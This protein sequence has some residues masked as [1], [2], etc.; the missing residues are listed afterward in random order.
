MIYRKQ[1][2]R[3][4]FPGGFFHLQDE[5]SKTRVSGFGNGEYIR[6]KDE[7]GNIWQ[8]SAEHGLGTS[9]VYRFKD[10]RGRTLTGVSEDLVVTLRD[11][12]GNTWKGIIA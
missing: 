5:K 10:G 12:S 4:Q 6:L 3:K 9:V 7:Y 11:E 1:R 2:S 8:G